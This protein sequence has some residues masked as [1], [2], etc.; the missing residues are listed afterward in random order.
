MDIV[1]SPS[2]RAGGSYRISWFEAP[3]DRKTGAWKEHVIEDPVETVHHFVGAADFNND[4]D[5]DIATAA[6]QQ[7]KSPKITV[8][9]NGGK[10]EKWIKNVVAPVSSHSMRV[11]D[12]DGDGL[13]DLYGGGLARTPGE[14]WRTSP[15]VAQRHH[16]HA[17]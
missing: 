1:L 5:V 2:E 6:W 15:E 17:A 4:G 14:Y 11:L 12:V 7:G 8:Y 10:G 3:R 16:G 13:P 9:V